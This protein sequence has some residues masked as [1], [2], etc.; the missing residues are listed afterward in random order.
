MEP[1]NVDVQA[2]VASFFVRVEGRRGT[3]DELVERVVDLQ[4]EQLLGG[5]GARP[6]AEKVLEEMRT[7]AHSATVSLAAAKLLLALDDSESQVLQILVE[8]LNADDSTLKV[9]P[10]VYH[11]NDLTFVQGCLQARAFVQRFLSADAL[12]SFDTAASE[13]FPLAD[14]FERD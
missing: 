8:G 1:T 4:R 3:M 11:L 10:A 7:S 5:V 12:L 2:S 14:K 6:F 13:R 9:A